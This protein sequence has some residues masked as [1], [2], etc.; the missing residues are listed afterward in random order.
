[1][2]DRKP[3]LIC[4]KARIPPDMIY[5]FEVREFEKPEAD[6]EFKS[7]MLPV[8]AIK[9]QDGVYLPVGIVYLAIDENGKPL[10]LHSTTAQPK[11]VSRKILIKGD[12]TD[13]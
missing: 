7:D 13:G 4:F 5:E 8:R 12:R 11:P 10:P 6:A 2:P 9:T 3:M 1:M